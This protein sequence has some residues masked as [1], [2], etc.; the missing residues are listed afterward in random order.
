[1][2]FYKLNQRSRLRSNYCCETLVTF[3]GD[4]SSWRRSILWRF[5]PKLHTVG[6]FA[7][8]T[9]TPL[10][11]PWRPEKMPS[12]SSTNTPKMTIDVVVYSECS[13]L[14]LVRVRETIQLSF[15]CIGLWLKRNSHMWFLANLAR[16]QCSPDHEGNDVFR[17][18]SVSHVLVFIHAHHMEI[19]QPKKM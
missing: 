5:S 7:T 12:H 4:G 16:W 13:L 2:I 18:W 6:P 10:Q 19:G 3:F 8:T 17:C 15:H 1:M 9:S 14:V 11:R